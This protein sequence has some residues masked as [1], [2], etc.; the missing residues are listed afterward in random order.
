MSKKRF[1]SLMKMNKLFPLLILLTLTVNTLGKIDSLTVSLLYPAYPSNFRYH[2]MTLEISID[3][4]T[5]YS[6]GISKFNRDSIAG[7]EFNLH[8]SG[9]D[10]LFLYI[11]SIKL[12]GVNEIKTVEDFEAYNLGSIGNTHLPD[13]FWGIKLAPNGTVGICDIVEGNSKCLKYGGCNFLGVMFGYIRTLYFG[14]YDSTSG[15]IIDYQNWTD[16]QTI[17]MQI[18]RVDYTTNSLNHEQNQKNN[19][20]HIYQNHRNKIIY[21]NLPELNKPSNIL[22][23]TISGKLINQFNNVSTKTFV[24]QPEGLSEGAY[25]VKAITGNNVYSYLLLLK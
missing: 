1:K 14:Q 9:Y 18:K 19:K 23:Y 5:R 15:P 8:H 6:M 12:T 20:L 4:W 22:V 17:S 2:I 3:T 10:S 16:Y 11:D 24:W 21:I 7:I 13:R 25:I